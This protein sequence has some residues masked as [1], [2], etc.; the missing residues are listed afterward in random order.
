MDSFLRTHLDMIEEREFVLLEIERALFTKRYKLSKKH[1]E[2]FSVQ[3]ISMVYAVWEGFVQNT[4]RDYIQYLDSL[5]IQF[6]LLD[7]SITI[8]HMENKFKQFYDYPQKDTKKIAFYA[9]LAEHY[10]NNIVALCPIVN[11][12]SNVS[13]E[14]LNKLLKQFALEPFQEQWEDYHYPN[15]NLKET[16]GT[17]LRYRNGIAH[18]GDT[19]SEEKVTVEVYEKYRRLV[20]DLMYGIHAKLENAITDERFL[21]H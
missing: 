19:S 1:F 15:P 13:F 20:V 8:F 21:K 6:A 17:F 11:T 5:H 14:V 7:N 12:E 10:E 4:F 2:I 18:G 9:Q 3:S 16:M